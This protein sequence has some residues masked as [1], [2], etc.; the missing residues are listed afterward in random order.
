MSRCA[1]IRQW[2]IDN[3]GWHFAG[4]VV[5]GMGAAGHERLR[6]SQQLCR[7]SA[8]GILRATGKRGSMRFQ[9]H[10]HARKLTPKAIA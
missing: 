4:D 10:R 3:P 9:F 1:R 7:M 8:A 6:V 5:E 2:L